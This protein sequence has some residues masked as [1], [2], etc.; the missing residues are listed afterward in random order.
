MKRIFLLLVCL[1]TLNN[2]QAQNTAYANRMQHVFGNINTS[3]VTTGYLKEFGVRFANIEACN[4]NLSANNF[5]TKSEWYALYSSLYSMRVGQVAINMDSPHNVNIQTKTLQNNTDNILIAAQHYN[6]QQYKTNA[7][8]NGDVIISN[9][10]IFDVNGRNPYDNKTLFATT[11]LK[12]Y[13]QGN[14]FVFK[15][16]S[17]LI[18]SNINNT[19]TQIQIDFDD[20]QGY[21]MVRQNEQ[22]SVTYTSGG[23][24][25]IK[26][27]FQYANENIVESHSKIWV[28]YISPQQNT[29]TRYNGVGFLNQNGA[30]WFNRPITGN[31]WNGNSATGRVT[32]EL[33]PGHTQ[34]TKPLIVIEGFDPEDSFNYFS[35]INTDGPGGLFVNISNTGNFNSLNQAIEDQDYDLVFVDFVNSTDFIQRNAYMVEEVIRQV[36]QMK[37]GN[38]KNVVLGMSMGGLVGRYALRHMEIEGENHDTKLYISHDTPH[39]G[40]NVPLAAQAMVRHLVGEEISLPV[41]LSLFNINILDLSDAIPDLQEGLDLLQSPAAKQMLIYQ[42]QGTGDNLSINT[43]SLHSSFL[44]EYKSMGYPQQNNIR[45]IAIASGSEC[46][47]PLGFNPYD[48]ILNAN[49]NVDISAFNGI[50]AVLNFISLNPLKFISSLLSTDTD[51]RADFSVR[52]L[53]SLQSKQIYRGRIFIKKTIL[54]VISVHEHLIDQETLNSSSN[55]LALD[56]AN[57][58]IY[59]IENFA[60][61]PNELNSYV[62]QRRFNFIPTFSSLDV[63]SGNTTINPSDL[64]KQYNPQLP[65]PA[66]K[67][68][69][70]DN[71]F[72]NPRISEGHIQF[73]LNNG[74]WLLSELS[75]NP[76]I[77]SCAF[78]CSGSEITGTNV[79]CNSAV[80][81]AP[82]GAT[83]YN[84]QIIQ[85]GHLVSMTGNGTRQ[86]TLNRSNSASGFVRIRITYGDN[87]FGR[88]GN[89]TLE[90]EVWVGTLNFNSISNINP[91]LYPHLSPIA[92]DPINN[93]QT[94]GFEVKF[95]PLTQNVLEYQ[96]E[97]VTQDVAWQR[98]Y[99]PNDAS[100]RAI[101]FPT[102]NKDFVFK[103]RARNACG[104][105][106]WFELTYA[107]NTCNNACPPPFSG[108]IGNNFI[109]TP[110]PVTNGMLNVS[111][112]PNAPWFPSL[113]VIPNP[114][115]IGISPIDGGGGMN[116]P[117]RVNITVANQMGVIVLNFPNTLMPANLNLSS[118][119]SGTYLVIFEYLGQIESHTIIKQ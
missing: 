64:H 71:F 60:S 33:A 113:E 24:K 72:T 30:L 14:S 87:N 55:M 119:P 39:Q 38:E 31:P 102:C 49:I 35:L 29:Q 111:I 73:T 15:L 106:Q 67:D 53:P 68:I 103:V 6:Y 54:W 9:D 11:T 48:H 70:F 117:I 86:I 45:N 96:W 20:R 118:L 100:N 47:N 1:V 34:L 32:I 8:T 92:H 59:D 21:Q 18:F 51:L 12:Q 76:Q 97:K 112:K 94:I 40:A 56:N 104:W 63:G 23:E 109:L 13:I 93:C 110:N 114:N 108:I 98:D 52:A 84:W 62:F 44:N 61:L 83:F 85:G 58:G 89:A 99:E 27:K 82:Q 7:R 95:W 28:D 80:Y 105:S 91:N 42:L 37:V 88:C 78:V 79:F 74:N 65:P 77:E 43:N 107:M 2:L 36:N 4:G 5:V 57:G 50:L 115:E 19:I 90:K 17:D 101:I 41:F 25:I 3:K 66:P 16:P 75:D 26:V 116:R 46:G 81:S 22:K 10:R 69:P